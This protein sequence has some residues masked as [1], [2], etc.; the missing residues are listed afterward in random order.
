V[1]EEDR[2][3][4]T[5]LNQGNFFEPT[6]MAI[7]PNLDILVAQRRGEMMLYS[8]QYKTG[9]AGRFFECIPSNADTPNVNAEEGVLGLTIDPDYKTTL[10][11]CFLQPYRYIGQPAVPL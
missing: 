8:E 9:K 1:P 5:V 4:K 6:E 3:V 11:L 7:L 10:C 2:F